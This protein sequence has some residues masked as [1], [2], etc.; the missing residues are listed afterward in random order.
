MR[1]ER[2][3]QTQL[4]MGGNGLW[5]RLPG[6]SRKKCRELLSRLLL[7]V[8]TAEAKGE[9]ADDEREDRTAAS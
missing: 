2:V 1:R 4:P 8:V 5:D 7:T 9:E 3:R 6:L